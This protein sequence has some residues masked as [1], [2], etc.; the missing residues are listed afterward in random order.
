M[1]GIKKPKVV[2]KPKTGLIGYARVSTA[3]QNLDMQIA[4]LEKV[5]CENIYSEHVSAASSKRYQLML[6]L[7][8][9][10]PGET[11]VVWRMDRLARSIRDLFK[12][13]QD[14]EDMGCKFRSLTENFDTTTAAGRL[15]LHVLAAMAEFERDLTVERTQ[16]GLR[17]ARERGQI[18]GA[19][20][21]VNPKKFAAIK[22]D[23]AK[24][25]LSVADVAK[26]HGIATSTIYY[27]FPGGRKKAQLA[28][29]RETR[30]ALK[31]T[32][33]TIESIWSRKQRSKH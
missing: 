3:E 15:L 9:L 18:L 5:G 31:K 19:K 32:V 4:A 24:R 12:K 23:L 27:L 30:K 17:R 28:K 29:V 21:K 8:D 10:Q 13:L 6:A 26:K 20:P 2:E 16:A 22:A 25:D 1:A 33:H 11:L 14:L 7:K